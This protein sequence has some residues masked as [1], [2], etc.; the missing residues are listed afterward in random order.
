[1]N[2]P[3]ISSLGTKLFGAGTSY[4]LSDD[5]CDELLSY[6]CKLVDEGKSVDEIIASVKKEK[7]ITLAKADA[8][9][10]ATARGICF[11]RG[12]EHLAFITKGCTKKDIAALVLRMMASDD[13]AETFMDKANG[14]SPYAKG[15]STTSEFNFVNQAK[16]LSYNPHFRAINSRIY[17]TRFKVMSSDYM[18]P[19]LNNLAKTMY[20]KSPNDTYKKAATDMYN[21]ALS[22]VQALWANYTK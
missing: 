22:E 10:V 13:Y 5:D 3:V 19:N 20:S 6:V 16:A 2:V 7:S 8:E 9:A 17:G 1:M 15:V 21:K 4:N 18:L 11:S 14:A 12:I